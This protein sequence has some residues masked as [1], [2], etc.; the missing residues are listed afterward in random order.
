MTQIRKFCFKSSKKLNEKLSEMDQI[1]LPICRLRA[2]ESRLW[3]DTIY[4]GGKKHGTK[5]T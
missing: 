2:C 3:W 5:L 1:V 4:I